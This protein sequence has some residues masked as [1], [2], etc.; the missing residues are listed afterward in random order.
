LCQC[1]L[2]CKY[3]TLISNACQLLVAVN[4]KLLLRQ[5]FFSG[6]VAACNKEVV[7]PVYLHT[8]IFQIDGISGRLPSIALH[9]N[10]TQLN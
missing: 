9:R 7:F 10:Q 2:R 1:T 8:L 3:L 4:K 6:I 5:L